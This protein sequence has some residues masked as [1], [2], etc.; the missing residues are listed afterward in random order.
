MSTDLANTLRA[1]I[2]ASGIS[3][4][5]LGI[6]TGVNQTTISR[7]LAGSDMTLAT[8]SVLAEHLGVSVAVEKQTRAPKLPRGRPPASQ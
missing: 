5:Q 4:R 7:F 6:A 8:A 1:A 2:T 3:A